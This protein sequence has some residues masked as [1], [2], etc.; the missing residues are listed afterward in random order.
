M[1]L[2]VILALL[3]A[4]TASARILPGSGD[5]PPD[6]WGEHDAPGGCSN[7]I[8]SSEDNN[9]RGALTKWINYKSA[10]NS[11]S[12]CNRRCKCPCAS[13]CGDALSKVSDACDRNRALPPDASAFESAVLDPEDVFK[14]DNCGATSSVE[15]YEANTDHMAIRNGN[16]AVSYT[17]VYAPWTRTASIMGGIKSCCAQAAKQSKESELQGCN[18]DFVEKTLEFAPFA[19]RSGFQLPSRFGPALLGPEA[20]WGA[21]S[22]LNQM[23]NLHALPLPTPNRFEEAD[24]LISLMEVADSAQVGWTCW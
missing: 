4:G 22:A 2:Y 11:E 12:W 24:D 23:F 3:I 19:K 8:F 7:S 14:A 18:K 20:S 9:T 10:Q 1:K 6:G 13:V 21:G 15:C 17:R 5:S 16:G